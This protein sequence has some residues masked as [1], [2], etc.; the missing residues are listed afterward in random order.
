MR[1]WKRHATENARRPHGIVVE[2]PP[3]GGMLA[4]PGKALTF[5]R[6]PAGRLRFHEDIGHDAA[7]VPLHRHLWQTERFTVLY[8][9][10]TLT[11]DGTS[12]DMNA[13]DSLDVPP[14]TLHSY[15]PAVTDGPAG[16]VLI[17]VEMWPALRAGQFFETIYALTREGGLP[18]RD[19]RDVL[20]L[21]ALSHAHGFMI[22]GPPVALM[23]IASAVG[24]AIAALFRIDHWSPQ[25]AARPPAAAPAPPIY[26]PG[27]SDA[28]P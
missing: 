27:Y 18:P 4:V 12:I 24:A 16:S 9:R 22:G 17:E 3:A 7:P 8:G 2:Q 23:R 5:V 19:I 11:C 25:F 28:G 10:L 21:L 26:L 13:G 6:A 20:R 15:A 14:L 1:L